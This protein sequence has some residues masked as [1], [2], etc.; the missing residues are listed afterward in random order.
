MKYISA[1]IN[2]N[3]TMELH[4]GDVDQ[5]GILRFLLKQ[6]EIYIVT[7]STPPTPSSD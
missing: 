5:A 1:Y 3:V 4:I 2:P 6:Q 7:L